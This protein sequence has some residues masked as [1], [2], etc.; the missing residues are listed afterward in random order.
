MTLPDRIAALDGPSREVDAEIARFIGLHIIASPRFVLADPFGKSSEMREVPETTAPLYTASIDAAMT[1]VPKGLRLLLSE[2]DDE[3]HLRPKG[4]WQA[5]LSKPGCDAS[6]DAMRGFR[7]DH[8]ATPALAL[9]A[10]ALKARMKDLHDE[11]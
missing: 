5:V 2:W 7:C 3:K 9:C 11:S 10:A 4:A 8:A 1:L 6:F